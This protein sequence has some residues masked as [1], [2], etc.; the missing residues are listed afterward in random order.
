MPFEGN[1]SSWLEQ[2]EAR[3]AQ[4]EKSNEARRRSLQR[5]LEVGPGG[6]EGRRS[7]GA[8]PD[9]PLTKLQQEA[10]QSTDADRRLEI[11]IPPGPTPRRHRDRGRGPEEGVRREAA[12]RRPL[13][14]APRPPAS[15]A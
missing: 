9:S 6:A 11:A 1:Y 3:L 13:V 7:E 12:V 5:E 15:S 14:H 2:K 4:E 8:R 10:E